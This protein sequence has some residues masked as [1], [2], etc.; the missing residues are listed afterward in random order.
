MK[1]PGCCPVCRGELVKMFRPT[2]KHGR[3]TGY[4]TIYVKLF[5][6]ETCRLSVRLSRIPRN[7]ALLR[8][9]PSG[10]DGHLEDPAA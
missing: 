10:R 1:E 3:S 7:P 4:Y 2:R 8:R 5:V 9:K 6:C